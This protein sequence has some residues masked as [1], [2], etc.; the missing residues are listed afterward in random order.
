MC[1]FN[2]Y[3][4][5]CYFNVVAKFILSL[6]KEELILSKLLRVNSEMIIG[7][8]LEIGIQ[9][10]YVI[11]LNS[12]SGI[13]NFIIDD[14]LIPGKGMVTDLYVVISS[15]KDSINEA[16]KFGVADIGNVS[17]EALD[18]S[19]GAPDNIIFLDTCELS[20]YGCVFWL[21]F[22][23]DEERLFYSIDYEKTIQEKRYPRGTVEKLINSVPDA[24]HLKIKRID[25]MITITD[26][27][28]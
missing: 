18:F 4:V 25:N 26:I 23:G 15:L 14:T 6:L 21:G 27:V 20:D 5:L 22:D 12:P 10:E 17:I 7:N 3:L 16:L 28:I 13:F 2:N 24:H 8:P 19:D 11:Q 9:V 1:A